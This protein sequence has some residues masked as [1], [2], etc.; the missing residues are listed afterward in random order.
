MLKIGMEIEKSVASTFALNLPSIMPDEFF[1]GYLGRFSICNDLGNKDQTNDHLKRLFKELDP[2]QS[3]IPL[4]MKLAQMLSISPKLFV[5]NHMLIRFIRSS[6]LM[7]KEDHHIDVIHAIGNRMI[8]RNAYF[9]EACVKEDKG[10]WGFSYY[11][12]S[13]QLPG[14]DTCSKHDEAL[15]MSTGNDPFHTFPDA[16]LNNKTFIKSDISSEEK[17]NP[18]RLKFEQLVD[19][20][21]DID[22]VINH[23][24]LTQLLFKNLKALDA[25]SKQENTSRKVFNLIAEKYPSTW[26]KTKFPLIY[27]KI[28]KNSPSQTARFYPSR[29]LSTIQILLGIPLLTPNASSQILSYSECMPSSPYVKKSD[30]SEKQLLK[31]YVKSKGNI[32]EVSRS[33]DRNYSKLLYKMLSIG[34]PS[35]VKINIETMNALKAFFNGES[36]DK[37]L[38]RPNIKIDIFSEIL[39]VGGTNINRAISY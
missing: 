26:I 2:D 20:F 6:K 38:L 31:A 37:V 8:Y 11:R 29:S 12:K 19:D 36:L 7:L 10:Y 32:M 28:Q 22:F 4:A 15:C 1:L 17:M 25:E 27:E 9:C 14:V 33:V 13:H 35:L 23:K 34:C 24:A 18:Y 3:D 5:K 21:M 30:V 39:R 16:Q